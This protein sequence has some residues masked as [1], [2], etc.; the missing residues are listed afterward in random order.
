MGVLLEG[1]HAHAGPAR[2]NPRARLKTPTPTPSPHPTPQVL[3]RIKDP[4][5]TLI[6]REDPATAY[7]VLCHARLLVARAPILFEGDYQVGVR[8]GF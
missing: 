1:L 4:L 2:L 3:E 7:A 8:L 5:K 6:A